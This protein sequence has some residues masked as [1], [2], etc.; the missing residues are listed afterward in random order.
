MNRFYLSGNGTGMHRA[1]QYSAQIV[2]L[3]TKTANSLWA[4][5]TKSVLSSVAHSWPA[6]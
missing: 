6:I 5:A 2:M 1:I 4:R 3:N